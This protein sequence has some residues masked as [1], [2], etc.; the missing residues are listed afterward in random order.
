MPRAHREPDLHA[1]L[2][3]PQRLSGPGAGDRVF[4]PGPRRVRQRRGDAGLVEP[5]LS[6][7]REGRS[8]TVRGRRREARGASSSRSGRTSAAF[9]RRRTIKRFNWDVAKGARSRST[10]CSSRARKPLDV[11]LSRGQPVPAE[12]A[13]HDRFDT[14]DRRPR[15]TQTNFAITNDSI[16]FYFSQG[17][18]FAESAGPVEAKVPRALVAPMLAV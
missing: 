6:A 3:L 14:A 12:G 9:I 5:A 8:V 2:Q 16:D 15:S 17:E 13:G 18:M 1:G 10:L 11:D 4:D 7:R